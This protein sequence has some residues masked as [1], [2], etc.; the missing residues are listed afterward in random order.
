M[1][2]QYVDEVVG[3]KASSAAGSLSPGGVLLLENVRF[4]KGETKNVPAFAEVSYRKKNYIR[5]H[6]RVCVLA[7]VLGCVRLSFLLL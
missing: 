3:E 2:V 5:V 4:N 6:G 7:C 1:D